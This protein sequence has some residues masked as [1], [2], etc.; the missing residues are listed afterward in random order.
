MKS[1]PRAPRTPVTT[2]VRS[3]TPLSVEQLESRLM[4][5][6]DAIEMGLQAALAAETHE[7]GP[8]LPES[9]YFQSGLF[10]NGSNEEP[11]IAVPLTIAGGNVVTTRTVNASIL[12]ADDQG[13]ANLKY[14]WKVLE[15]PNDV[16]ISFAQHAT[17]GAKNNTL[18]FDRAGDYR[19]RVGIVDNGGLKATAELSFK[20]VSSL[21]T[22]RVIKPDNTAI[23]INGAYVTPSA[24][25]KFRI[26]A[27]DQFGNAMSEIPAVN[28]TLLKANV[29]GEMRVLENDNGTD[30]AF[31][32]AGRYVVRV[33]SGDMTYKFA[34]FV[35]ET[36]KPTYWDILDKDGK[37]VSNPDPNQ[38]ASDNT[39][40]TVRIRDQFRDV[41]AKPAEIS[42]TIQLAPLGGSTDITNDGE[43]ANLEFSSAGLY[44]VRFT[45]GGK[46]RNVNIQVNPVL[47]TLEVTP[48]TSNVSAGATLQFVVR[49]KDQFGDYMT[50]SPSVTWSASGGT[51]SNKGL[52]TAG[53]LAGAASV[54]ATSGSIS[55]TASVTV[56]VVSVLTS[57]ELTPNTAS[58]DASASQQ[59]VVRGKDQ[60]G[61]YM[62]GTPTVT[63]S[64][65]GGTVSNSG[66]FTAGS[67][68]GNF[69]VTVT[70]GTITASSTVTV[71]VPAVLTT[72]ELTPNTASLDA[73]ATQQFVVRGKDQFGNYMTGTPAVTWSKTGGG[74][75][76]NTGLF[77]AGALAGAASVKVTSG[78]ITATAAITITIPA[79]LTSLEVT[80]STNALN[81]GETKQFVVRGLDQFGNYM[82][83]TPTVTW[84][85][86]GGTI[87]TAGLYT[88]GSTAGNATVTATSGTITASAAITISV[89]AV[90]T[91]LELTPNTASIDAG[92]TQQFVVRGKDQFGNY[93]TG[94]PAVTW[95]KTGGGTVSNTGLFTAG[96]LAGAAS[97]KVT[98]GTI[99]ATA[100]ITITIPAVLTSLEVTPGTN[101]LNAGETK[102]FEVRGLDQFGNYM[103]GTPTVTWTATGGTITTAGLYTAGA[104]AGNATVTATSG[105]ITASAAITISVPAVLTSL[106]LTP[107]TASLDAGATQQFVVRGKD[108]FGNYMTGTPAVTWSA[109][110]GTVSNAGLFTAGT[111]AGNASVTVT[112]GSIT[113]TAA[114]TVSVPAVLTSLELT[115]NTVAVNTGATQQFVVRGKDQFGN[116]MNGTPTVTWSATGGTVSSS[117]LFTAG[118]TAGN[119]SVTVTK[120]SLTST[121][122]IVIGIFQN[123]P[124][125]QLIYSYYVDQS[126]NRTEMIQILRSVGSD[127][128]VD[129]TEL[130]DLRLLV[131]TTAFV[132]AG[133]VRELARDVVFDSPANAKFQGQTLGNL[134]AGS[135]STLLNKLVDK[136]F[137][138]ADV[139]ALIG[140]GI[141]YR[142][143]TGTLF[144]NNPSLNDAK[145]GLVGDCYFIVSMVSIANKN[146]DAIRDMFVDNGDGTFTVRFFASGVADY[147]TV[148]R[149]L[150]TYSNGNLAYSGSGHSA[151]SASTTLWI[152]LAEKAYAQ[153]NE[154]GKAGR[155]G[156]NTYSG[157][158]GGWM[159][160]TNA[161]VLGYNSS[162][163]FFSSSQPQVMI[164][165]LAAGKSVSVG[166]Y[167]SVGNGLVGGHAYT[168]VRYEPSNGTF[169][170]D[171]PWGF[172]DP[173][174]LT[175]AQLVANCIL[176]TTTDPA[177]SG[178]IDPPGG[179]GDA[180]FV[181]IAIMPTQEFP[182][183]SPS[184][185]D[186]PIDSELHA[187]RLEPHSGAL[188]PDQEFPGMDYA[189]VIE[190]DGWSEERGSDASD[191]PSSDSLVLEFALMDLYRT[192][193]FA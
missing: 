77:T 96:A 125:S 40:F 86:T 101:A 24:T 37:P 10:S 80:P 178:P 130:A 84:T 159:H 149:Q 11:T 184:E 55:A 81:A 78:T 154:T 147:V 121:A 113:S 27:R 168:V 164:D 139:P 188:H 166:T 192:H 141:A 189:A 170:L 106:E 75:V 12:G 183:D 68:A 44:Q 138:G 95:S 59:F 175:W 124:L 2:P 104:T 179:L 31:S 191:M 117:G 7:M 133:Y 1:Q 131:N 103:T 114:I 69:K 176:F 72:L 146:P 45:G 110:L 111:V 167:G 9:A 172:N 107:N 116:Y 58:L 74:T 151:L 22:F 182:S 112:S 71:N 163:F 30:L 21:T 52:F 177:G 136:W 53:S 82:T 181:G 48:S 142:E 119:A 171:N 41:M 39:Q 144:V 64:A 155:N 38:I 99:T 109:T 193:A 186:T 156:T 49:G 87:T 26:E 66:L 46:S 115:P 153:W 157:I 5:A 43:I 135:S 185:S 8:H 88:A 123:Q 174:A 56:T 187:F 162:N 129:A 14:Y 6:A 126:I 128:L 137:Y 79:V 20:V 16:G 54:T 122:S 35:N 173:A 60:F 73:G 94:T 97:V 4:M 143:S 29:A 47:T 18:R 67:V 34:V 50:G 13:E 169:V 89:P 62:T 108:Q 3:N 140:S 145:Q 160:N 85:A 92:S 132:M 65:T 102:Q 63:W 105:T 93:M 23:P 17:N 57:L 76:S 134:A 33:T 90:L 36:P 70:S 28:W 120:G 165:A 150:P 100:A 127:S 51:V 32:E 161:Q 148:N 83:G 98:S 158:E 152:A 25:A 15:S 19:I 91:S 180:A 190:A 118:S 61:N 42:W